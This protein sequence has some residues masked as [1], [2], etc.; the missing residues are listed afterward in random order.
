M[1]NHGWQ[2]GAGPGQVTE[3]LTDN[4]NLGSA[5]WVCNLGS[6]QDNLSEISTVNLPDTLDFG[7]YIAFSAVKTQ[8]KQ[9]LGGAVQSRVVRVDPTL[10]SCAVLE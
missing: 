8:F 2:F 9:N 6:D 3:R 1:N 5:I 10:I 7:A 4:Y